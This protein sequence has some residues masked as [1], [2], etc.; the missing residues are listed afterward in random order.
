MLLIVN[1]FDT[2]P[3][4]C[5][6]ELLLTLYLSTMGSLTGI[7]VDLFRDSMLSRYSINEGP[8]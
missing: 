6:C 3:L 7:S 5:F 4:V 8:L 2:L 1:V